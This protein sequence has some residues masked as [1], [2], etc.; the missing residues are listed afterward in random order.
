MTNVNFRSD[1]VK[2][3]LIV[4]RVINLHFQRSVVRY[5]RI[6]CANAKH[7]RRAFPDHCS[8]SYQH[9]LKF[10][11]DPVARNAHEKFHDTPA[12]CVMQNV[13]F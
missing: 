5:W 4:Q 1:H 2:C 11:F 12:M 13:R 6:Y 3:V 7:S 9:P 10:T 8:T